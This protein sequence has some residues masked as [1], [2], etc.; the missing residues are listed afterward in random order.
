MYNKMVEG[1][2]WFS[3]GRFVKIMG[4]AHILLRSEALLLANYAGYLKLG[5]LSASIAGL[6]FIIASAFMMIILNDLYGIMVVYRKSMMCCISGSL[7][8]LESL[9]RGSS[10]SVKPR[11]RMYKAKAAI[12]VAAIIAMY[13]FNC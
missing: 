12:L 1:G 10:S 7:P 9:P 11:S 6:T 8:Y 2:H 13:F 5:L 3:K 4:F